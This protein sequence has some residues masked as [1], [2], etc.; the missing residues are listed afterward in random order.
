M[1]GQ[2]CW[3]LTRGS[4]G[5]ASSLAAMS[6]PMKMNIPEANAYSTPSP[7]PPTPLV[8]AAPIRIPTG[9]TSVNEP[10]QRTY[11][12]KLSCCGG[13]QKAAVRSAF[14]KFRVE[15]RNY[16]AEQGASGMRTPTAYEMIEG[17][18]SE[19]TNAFASLAGHTMAHSRLF[20]SATSAYIGVAA[21]RANVLEMRAV[22]HRLVGASVRYV[23]M[24]PATPAYLR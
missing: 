5:F 4:R 7:T 12:R 13:C 15:F 16:R 18:D 21:A 22:L 10:A 1:P 9:V 19:L 2:Q 14:D 11:A 23:A 3:L 20:S 24:H 8:R 17:P 6:T